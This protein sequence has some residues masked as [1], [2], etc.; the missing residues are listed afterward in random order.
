MKMSENGLA[1][2]RQF[3]SCRT[4]AYQDCAGVWTIGYGWTRPVNGVYIHA[5]MTLS[6][7][8]AE[9]LL[10]HGLCRYEQAVRSRVKVP[11]T[12]PQFD[13]LVDF[14]YNTGVTALVH[15]TLLTRLNSGDYRGAADELL[16][17]DRAGGKV[18]AGLARRRRAERA[19]FLS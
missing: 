8:T 18:L 4:T 3:E 14:T 2:L 15:S 1:L 17:W 10:Q 13:A 12:Q 7:V 11:L 16:R 6:K 9:N 19:L 5:G